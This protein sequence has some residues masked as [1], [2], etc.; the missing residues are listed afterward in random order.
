MYTLPRGVEVTVGCLQ[1]LIKLFVCMWMVALSLA[2]A[3]SETKPAR[4]GQDVYS[5][6]R[7]L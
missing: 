3:A 1:A 4:P 5:E 6:N 2:A 7:W